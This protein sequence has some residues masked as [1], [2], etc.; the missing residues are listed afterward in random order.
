M[1]LHYRHLRRRPGQETIVEAG[2]RRRLPSKSRHADEGR[3]GLPRRPAKLTNLAGQRKWKR[4]AP[5]PEGRR[6]HRALH[7][8]QPILCVS[9]TRDPREPQSPLDR[10][11]LTSRPDTLL[12]GFKLGRL[13]I[14]PAVVLAFCGYGACTNWDR[15][16]RLYRQ[17]PRAMKD[18]LRSG[19]RA[20]ADVGQDDF[21]AV[22][23]L[24]G[25]KGEDMRQLLAAFATQ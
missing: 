1:D 6:P 4:D 10:P 7:L 17:G 11:D 15:F 12:A 13:T 19:W 22:G 9:C 24:R 5:A 25:R 20:D 18:W 2:R 16:E 23:R 21:D 3:S 8:S 14:P